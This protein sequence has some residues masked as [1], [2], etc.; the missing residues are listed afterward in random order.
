MEQDLSCGCWLSF[1]HSRHG[2][3][4]AHRCVH[5]HWSVHTWPW[6]PKC[7]QGHIF[8]C[9]LKSWGTPINICSIQA[10]FHRFWFYP[11]LRSHQKSSPALTLCRRNQVLQSSCDSQ[12]VHSKHVCWNVAISWHATKEFAHKNF[13]PGTT[14]APF[15]YTSTFPIWNQLDWF[16]STLGPNQLQKRNA[17]SAHRRRHAHG[18]PQ[19][20][21]CSQT[22]GSTKA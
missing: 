6:A 15:H 10:T 12:R 7:L 1:T 20:H 2:S 9:L 22:H 16:H 19:T 18:R 5:A 21:R 4:H 11:S 3:S 13:Q 14:V 8:Q 17:S